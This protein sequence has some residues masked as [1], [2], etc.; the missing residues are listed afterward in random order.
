VDQGDTSTG[1]DRDRRWQSISGNWSELSE[2]FAS[3]G[4]ALR[5]QYDRDR[6][7]ESAREGA[8]EL[9]EAFDQAVDSF[10]HAIDA[11]ADAIRTPEVKAA[12]RLSASALGDAISRT[13]DAVAEEINDAIARRKGRQG[14]PDEGSGSAAAS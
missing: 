14:D 10:A 8:R 9:R 1:D 13:L 2:H 4:R 7:G 11:G 6:D 5:E 3:L 12:A